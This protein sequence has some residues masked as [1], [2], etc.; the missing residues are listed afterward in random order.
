M[1]LKHKYSIHMSL[2]ILFNDERQNRTNEP[3]SW[4]V[5]QMY[6]NNFNISIVFIN[7]FQHEFK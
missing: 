7:I 2:S 5:L 1:E 3:Q 6:T 4:L